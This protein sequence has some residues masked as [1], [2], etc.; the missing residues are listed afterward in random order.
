MALR[1][2]PIT[3]LSDHYSGDLG[4]TVAYCNLMV[5]SNAKIFYT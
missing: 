3:N 4:K 1:Q 2:V 5:N